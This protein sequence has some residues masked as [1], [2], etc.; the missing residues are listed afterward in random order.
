M[1]DGLHTN[2]TI[3]S[4]TQPHPYAFTHSHTN[5]HRTSTLTLLVVLMLIY[6][7]SLTPAPLIPR[8]RCR[9]TI[10]CAPTVAIVAPFAFPSKQPGKG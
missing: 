1:R 6:A 5:L 7:I 9:G 10:Y 8:T 3:D 4:Y 2:L